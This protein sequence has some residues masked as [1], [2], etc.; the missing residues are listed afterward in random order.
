M[1]DFSSDLNDIEIYSDEPLA[2]HSTIKIGGT[3]K[4]AAFPHSE[5]AFCRL[6]DKLHK[7]NIKFNV[8]GNASNTIFPDGVYDGMIVF[9]NKMNGISVVGKT[10]TAE[11]GVNCIYFSHFAMEH[12]LSGAEF[13][14]G[15]P[16]SV[17]GSVFMNAGAYGS[18]IS[19][20]IESS[21]LYLPNGTVAEIKKGEH[22]F[23]Y[24]SSSVKRNGA[25][26]ISSRFSLGYDSKEKIASRI[27]ELKEKRFTSQPVG[28]PSA[29]SVFLAENGIS[30]WK[31]IDGAGLRGL[32]IGG[33]QISDKHAGFI[34]NCG[35][36]TAYDVEKLV[37]IVKDTV[38]EKYGVELKTEIIFLK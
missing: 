26:V 9:T 1:L 25:F 22:E 8:I 29:G 30:A 27:N 10:I 13:L 32:K 31:Y 4:Y 19:D 38:F 6:L 20:I 12:S 37:G 36:A 2:R 35:G 11:C 15:I 21:K 33:A 5:E 17:G 3:A 18:S 16:G 7:N 24:R 23:G 14:S 28:L 34:V